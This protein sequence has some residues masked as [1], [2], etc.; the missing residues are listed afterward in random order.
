MKELYVYKYGDDGE[1]S[2]IMTRKRGE[3][4]KDGEID[5]GYELYN[6]IVEDYGGRWTN[7]APGPGW[8]IDKSQLQKLVK[9]LEYT[10][11]DDA[12]PKSESV[13]KPP[14]ESGSKRGDS[15]SVRDD[16]IRSV[17]D[18]D[19]GRESQRGSD[20]EDDIRSVRSSR[21]T[22]SNRSTSSRL[23]ERELARKRLQE[24]RSRY[25]EPDVAPDTPAYNKAESP[26][27]PG[28][29]DWSNKEVK[30]RIRALEDIIFN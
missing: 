24:Y 23:S 26:V 4:V 14:S 17:R 16:D 12:T 3:T 25:I 1:S 8:I 18:L 6:S 15:E 22:R 29:P 19:I 28:S 5:Q 11:D 13:E 2:I 21:S 30:R 20:K 9:Y 27:R 10:G 7:R